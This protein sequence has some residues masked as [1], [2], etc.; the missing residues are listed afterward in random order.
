VLG[1]W[2]EG[3][4]AEFAQRVV[5]ALEEL[6]RERETGAVATEALGGLLV[7]GAIR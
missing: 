5:A 7:V 1:R 3:V 2:R 6:A 4:I